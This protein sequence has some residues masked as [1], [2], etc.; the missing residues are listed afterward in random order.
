M[1][2]QASGAVRPRVLI[3]DDECV[4]ADTLG[5]IL[6]Q[7]GFEATAVYN[8]SKAVDTAHAFRPDI[9]LGDVVMPGM[10]GIEAAIRI[11][12]MIPECR[13]LLLSGQAATSDLLHDAR[14]SGH[15]FEVLL[16]PVHPTQL[17]KRLRNDP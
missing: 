6:N 11:C 8:G 16:K 4:I 15:E 17:L 5:L 3:A 1:D 13:V 14:M 10:S 2:S 9:F 12:A 7:S